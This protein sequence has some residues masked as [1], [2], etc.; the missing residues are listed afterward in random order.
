M[1]PAH[2]S[3]LQ[4]P[5]HRN[6]A[7]ASVGP[8]HYTTTMPPPRLL[9]AFFTIVPLSPPIW[10]GGGLLGV[11]PMVAVEAAPVDP[12]GLRLAMDRC[13]WEFL[14]RHRGVSHQLQIGQHG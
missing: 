11:P 6:P 10:R 7:T 3:R 4:Q 1:P 8:L 2:A 13:S 9:Q 12:L 5:L 14:L